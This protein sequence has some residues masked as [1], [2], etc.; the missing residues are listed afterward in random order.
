M[1]V[2]D[3][4]SDGTV[5]MVEKFIATHSEEPLR[6]VRQPHRGKGGAVTT[7]LMSAHTQVACFSDLDLATPLDDLARLVEA[8]TVAPMLAIGSRGVAS[9][10][11]T[12]HRPRGRE[13]LGRAYNKAIQFS[14][15][16]GIVDTQCGAKVAPTSVWTRIL[17]HCKEEGFAWDVEVLAL[18]RAMGIQV[19]EFGVEWAHQEGSRVK[20]LHDG[21]RIVRVHSAYPSQPSRLHTIESV[22]F[23]RRR[24]CFRQ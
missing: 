2:D 10:R 23:Q 15:L 12:R 3:G 1:F 6:L 4:S 13:V 19:R 24:R 20:V 22:G 9:A 17:L 16:P 8:A 18:A 5:Q 14:L 11:I 21:T 7:G